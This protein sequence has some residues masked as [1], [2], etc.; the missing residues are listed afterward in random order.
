MRAS[1][2]NINF[3]GYRMFKRLRAITSS[4]AA[5]RATSFAAAAVLAGALTI[6]NVAP[7]SATSGYGYDGTDP[8]AT[9]CS[10]SAITIASGTLTDPFTHAATGNWEVR[11]SNVCG[12]NWVRAYSYNSSY[13]VKKWIQ[14]TSDGYA[15]SDDDVYAGW[16]WG[17][18]LY[19]PG[20]T[21][22][23]VNVILSDGNF[24]H[25]EVYQT[26]C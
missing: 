24:K 11:Y 13:I 21:C 5:R 14:R 26:F 12:T 6:A 9:G 20:S 2:T 4:K 18:Q 23:N 19:A 17:R 25:G 3:G 7:A 22:I 16:T 10:N 8:S 1:R 15:L